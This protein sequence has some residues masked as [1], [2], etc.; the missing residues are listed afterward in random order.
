MDEVLAVS[1]A[2]LS[3]VELVWKLHTCIFQVLWKVGLKVNTEETNCVDLFQ[4]DRSE[5]NFNVNVAN[6]SFENVSKFKYIRTSVTNLYYFCEKFKNKINSGSY[7]V[8]LCP[9]FFFFQ[10]VNICWFVRL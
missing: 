3:S 8:L 5:Q 2:G 1:Q 7:L 10:P 4:Q 6:R 9:E